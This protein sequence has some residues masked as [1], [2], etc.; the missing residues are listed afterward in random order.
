MDKIYGF[1]NRFKNHSSVTDAFQYGCCY[2]FAKI[3]SER[4]CGVI[5]YD[6]VEN[7]FGTEI[8]GRVFDITGDVTERYLWYP[9]E[10]FKTEDPV[11]AARIEKN[12][13]KF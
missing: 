3:L 13:I 12:C 2:W 6:D 1:I 9:W 4:F 8:N 7:H 5:V 10:K 11:H